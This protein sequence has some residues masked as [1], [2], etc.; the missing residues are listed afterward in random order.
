[1][2]T[3]HLL[4][5]SIGSVTRISNARCRKAGLLVFLLL[6]FSCASPTEKESYLHVE[7]LDSPVKL[8]WGLMGRKSLPEDHAVLMHIVPPRRAAIW[9]MGIHF[10][11]DVAFLDSNGIIQE[12]HT[13]K[14]YPEKLDPKRPIKHPRDLFLYEENDPILVFFKQ[15]S[16]TPNNPCHYVLET[17]AGFFKKNNLNVGTRLDLFSHRSRIFFSEE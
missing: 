5:K 7:H 12:I 2:S 4:M 8:A 9:A 6:L 11:L 3:T 13:L 15:R 16:I 17:N 10:D 14:S 1:M